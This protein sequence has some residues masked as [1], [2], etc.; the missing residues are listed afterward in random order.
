MNPLLQV[1]EAYKRPAV[2]DSQLKQLLQVNGR[3]TESGYR[4]ISQLKQL[5]QVIEAH[6][7]PAIADFAGEPAP[8]GD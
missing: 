6:K 8:T 3:E 2:P 1:I 5:L 4:R 7:T